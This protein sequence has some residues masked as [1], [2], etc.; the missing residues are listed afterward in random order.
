LWSRAKL[1]LVV[2]RSGQPDVAVNEAGYHSE[3]AIRPRFV[4]QPFASVNPNPIWSDESSQS[5]TLLAGV[6]AG[7]EGISEFFVIASEAK[8]SISELAEAWIASSL[9]LLAMTSK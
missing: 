2:N 9:S 1:D 7:S 3:S 5:E 8:Q 6:V 4:P